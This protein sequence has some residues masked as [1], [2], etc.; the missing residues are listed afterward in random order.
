MDKKKILGFTVF[1]AAGFAIGLVYTQLT[2]PQQT[3]LSL[4]PNDP[5]VVQSG[6]E[7]YV[8][9]CASCHGANLEGQDK[10]RE[11]MENGKLPAPPHDETG[12]TWHH[13]DELLIDLTKRGPAAIVGTGY[14]SDMPGFKGVLSDQQIV[15]VLSYIKSQW[16]ENVRKRHDMLNERTKEP[17]S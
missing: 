4:A 11:P 3:T 17:Q 12:H 13:A 2:E 8:D 16:P 5:G 1:I 15:A 10:W 9:Q 7:I 6:E 14:D